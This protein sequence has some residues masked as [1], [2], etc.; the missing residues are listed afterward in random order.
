MEVDGLTGKTRFDQKSGYRNFFTLE[1]VEL[2]NSGFK[3]IGVW[4][5]ENKMAYTRTTNQ[6]LDD[7]VNANMNKTFIVATKIVRYACAAY[8]R[9]EM[10]L[11]RFRRR[12]HT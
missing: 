10:C 2:T 4:D 7:L 8:K 11:R 3:K 1:I 9:I 6:M 5:P 12:I